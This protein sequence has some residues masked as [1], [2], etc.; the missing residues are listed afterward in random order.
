MSLCGSVV[1]VLYNPGEMENQHSVVQKEFDALAA[2]YESNR[3]SRWYKAHSDEILNH[4]PQPITGDILEIGCATGHLLR[5]LSQ[6]APQAALVGIDVSPEMIAAANRKSAGASSSRLV[7][8]AD[9]WEDLG[10]NSL[11][12]LRRFNFQLIICAN[13][14]HYFRD[15]RKAS[16]KIYKMLGDNGILLVLEREK[17][18]SPLTTLWDLLHRYFIKDQVRFYGAGELVDLFRDAGFE[19]ARIVTTIRRYFWKG[20]LF[21]SIALIRCKKRMGDD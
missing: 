14:F 8:L 12:I 3:L 9:D 10:E 11:E 21:T 18:N 2:E 6:R 1:G 16:E 7:L 15:P 19:D 20:K 13:T 4:C 5:Q 17:L